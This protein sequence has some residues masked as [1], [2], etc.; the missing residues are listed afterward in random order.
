LTNETKTTKKT[1]TKTK[2]IILTKAIAKKIT[3]NC[4]FFAV[5][6]VFD[7][8]FVIKL[9]YVLNYLRYRCIIDKSFKK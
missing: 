9:K 3:A 6:N 7:N 5:F 1:K 2:K 4:F 8:F